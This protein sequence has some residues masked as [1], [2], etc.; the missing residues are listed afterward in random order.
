MLT[1]EREKNENQKGG[2]LEGGTASEEAL[3]SSK[4]LL[5]KSR[6][7][8]KGAQQF[9]SP[10]ELA[11]FVSKMIIG[12]IPVFD[13]T[14]GD[15][16]LLKNFEPG[17]SF[18]VELDADQV[19]AAQ[20][21][22]KAIK[23]DFQHVY[24]LLRRAG[25]EFGG[26]VA[27]PPFDLEWSDPSVDEGK[28]MSS[29]KLAYILA[30]RLLSHDGQ[31]IFVAGRD[32][33]ERECMD[34]PEADGIYAI[35]EVEDLFPDVRLPCVIVCGVSTE[36]HDDPD[37]VPA[38]QQLT[39]E[40]LGSMASMWA[41]EERRKFLGYA[42]VATHSY[43][44]HTLA[45]AWPAIQT[46]YERRLSLRM[47]TRKSAYDVYAE[48][49]V[50]RVEL[51]AYKKIVLARMGG[52]LRQLESLNRHQL[53]YFHTNESA[54]RSI[55]EAAEDDIITIDPALIVR[56]DEMLLESRKIITPLYEL[57]QVQRLGFLDEI[58]RI[59]CTLSDPEKGFIAGERYHIRTT[60][61]R[62]EDKDTRWEEN[63]KTGEIVQKDY[64]IS[65]RRM[66]IS[67]SNSKRNH[68][69]YDD[70]QHVQDIQYITDHFDVPDPGD[71]GT[72]FPEEVHRMRILLNE[73]E[74]DTI[75][76]NSARAQAADDP[77]VIAEI[78]KGNLEIVDYEEGGVRMRGVRLRKFQRED[79][80]R[81]LVKGSGMLAWEQGLGKTLGGL[82]YAEACKR[83]GAQEAVMIVAPGDLI[84]QWTRETK[85]FMGRDLE[86]IADKKI[87]IPN[88]EKGKG[89]K[90]VI[91]HKVPVQAVADGIAK[92]LK[93]GGT[94][95]YISY[96]EALTT[97][98]T[99]GKGKQEMLPM[100][101]I[102]EIEVPGRWVHGQYVYETN[103]ETGNVE[104]VWKEGH[105]E[106][107]TKKKVTNLEICPRCDADMRSGYNGIFCKAQITDS[108]VGRVGSV[109]GYT[110]RAI[111]VKPAGSYLAVAFKKGVVL[112]DEATM[113]GGSANGGDSK[114]SKVIRGI[115]ARNRLGMTGTPIKNYINQAFWLLRWSCDSKRFAYPWHNGKTQFEDDYGVIEWDYSN[116]LKDDRKLLPEI[117]NLSMLWKQLGSCLIR[118]RQEETGENIVA[119]R[120]H[121]HL[122]PL[123][124]AQRMQMQ[125]WMKDFYLLFAEKYPDSKVVKSGAHVAMA[126]ML[127]MMQKL[128]YASTLP[129]GDPDYAWTGIDV[130]NWTPVNLR[131]LELSMALAKEG[132]KVLVGSASRET[133]RW[134]AEQ[135]TDKGVRALHILE[136]D[137]TT[138]SAPK[139]AKVVH[140]FQTDD[141]QVFCAGIQAIRLGHNLDAGSAVIIHGPPWDW[142][143][144]DQ[145]VKR[146]RRLTSKRDIDVHIVLPTGAS[147]TIN[148]RKWALLMDK[149]DSTELA[150]DGKLTGR[151][152]EKRDK[153]KVMQEL[154]E[155]GL[156]AA[157]DE[158]L[159]QDIE[160]LWQRMPDI[161]NYEAPKNLTRGHTVA[162]RASWWTLME[163]FY[164]QTMMAALPVEA[165]YGGTRFGE[166]VMP[167]ITLV[168]AEGTKFSHLSP[169]PIFSPFAGFTPEELTLEE[170]ELAEETPSPAAAT[171]EPP[172]PTVTDTAPEEEAVTI[173]PAAAAT[174]GN[175]HQNDPAAVVAAI[176]EIKAL[177]EDGTLDD[178]EFKVAKT[179]LLDKLRSN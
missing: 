145:F 11:D 81:M 122:A 66:I 165:K 96:Y 121:E 83:L 166:K 178:E 147:E 146:V 43:G 139:R 148:Q 150:L 92:H 106:P 179:V 1:N 158:I 31:L 137:G 9:F 151:D 36:L 74:W 84:P 115:R 67:I 140:A 30:H 89:R 55:L 104:T 22:Y 130:S 173:P 163:P 153:E 94:G 39:T 136:E 176:K 69:F 58:D 124:E 68:N 15:G 174:N 70:A 53:N 108:Y 129:L 170:P 49:D 117:T 26:I 141:A 97:I 25:I 167:E 76:P 51:N 119:I 10:P 87:S 28:P 123:G 20:G 7:G 100:E 46:E 80:A 156:S 157:D 113:I 131:V 60:T 127:G 8:F 71:M 16:S 77:E 27:N 19:N 38:R 3:A 107:S 13:P 142:E 91:Q 143:S 111:M 47:E 64:L 65:R 102:R 56:V 133:G 57:K 101:V 112:V 37:F 177:H 41:T 135:L 61:S 42:R 162:K 109:C 40:Q 32:R 24:T 126:P 172:S 114:R 160:D 110:R 116:R 4:S 73:I 44:S 132:R 169:E 161:A 63:K 14:A 175:G 103:A 168:V 164:R 48:R 45:D 171:A 144:F 90:K 34:L 88:P 149:G 50:L 5:D 12:R 152:S 59:K 72:R 78:D 2:S 86:L 125:K 138:F 17:Y 134:L 82:V 75:I 128:E 154:A 62:Y 155:A 29:T 159:E 85:R 23:G 105:Q 35:I 21:S 18:G 33:F 99:R 98:G 6:F 54:W 118:R 95:W 52:K 120:Y 93:D 79:L